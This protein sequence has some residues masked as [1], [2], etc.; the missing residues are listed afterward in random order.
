MK[1]LGIHKILWF[2]LVLIFTLLELIIF[3]LPR[4]IISFL[5]CF[6]FCTSWES[7]QTYKV[8]NEKENYIEKVPYGD[9]NIIQ[10]IKRRY[11]FIFNYETRN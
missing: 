9:K 3:Y 5:W 10:T 11:Y 8:Y 1:Y 4:N 6:K 7:I 2:I